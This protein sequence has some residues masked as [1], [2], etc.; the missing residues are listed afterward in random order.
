MLRTTLR[1]TMLLAAMLQT[2]MA[3][4]YASGVLFPGSFRIRKLGIQYLLRQ[5]DVI[6]YNLSTSG[7]Y[8]VRGN[9]ADDLL[10]FV[11]DTLITQFVPG[12]GGVYIDN[13]QNA[14]INRLQFTDD[15]NT[16]RE[17]PF[18]STGIISFN[19]NLQNDT[20]PA[21]WWMF[22]TTTEFAASGYGQADAIIVENSVGN[23]LFG[24]VSAATHSFTFA[25]DTN[26]QPNGG[27]GINRTA[28]TDASVIV[29]AIGLDTAQFVNANL[30]IQR[31]TAN[32]VS[33]V[34]ALERNY[35]NPD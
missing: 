32:N 27:A 29:V 22:Y 1:L 17:F 2:R 21:R 30:T 16:I 28:G 35:S 6:N 31:T 24:T 14:D 19:E 25:Y 4:S 26:T 11:G 5:S 10:Q 18:T 3:T 9:T 33:L 15:T 8:P 7:A 34:A 13:F 20:G 23:Q 12:W